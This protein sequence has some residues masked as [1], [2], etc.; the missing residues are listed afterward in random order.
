MIFG[1]LSVCMYVCM[2][3]SLAPEVLDG[4]YSHSVSKDVSIRGRCPVNVNIPAQKIGPLKWAREL[5]M[6]IFSKRIL[7]TYF[8]AS[9]LWRRSP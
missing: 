4:I 5:K 3:D 9:N 8:N 7:T 6:A 2:Y 1:M